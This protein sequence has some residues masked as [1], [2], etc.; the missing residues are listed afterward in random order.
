MQPTKFHIATTDAT[1]ATATASGNTVTVTRVATG[2]AQI[3]VNT[4]EGNK[5]ATHTVT[6]S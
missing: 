6:V 4:V 3:V 2:T 5:V 1:K